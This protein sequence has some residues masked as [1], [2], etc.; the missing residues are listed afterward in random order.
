M[1]IGSRLWQKLGR[2]LKAGGAITMRVVLTWLSATSRQQNLLCKQGIRV[3]LW[4]N[5]Q[6]NFNAE[7]GPP[8]PSASA[9]S[10]ELELKEA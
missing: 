6:S 9:T 7:P 2:K 4:K 1:C 8:F 3:Q 5:Q 10:K